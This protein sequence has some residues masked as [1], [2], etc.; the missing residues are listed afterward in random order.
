MLGYQ[1]LSFSLIFEGHDGA[2]LWNEKLSVELSP[3]TD[4]A[5]IAIHTR[6]TFRFAGITPFFG[7]FNK[8]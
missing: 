2:D 6:T 7:F 5:Y 8:D 4:S 1:N 3:L